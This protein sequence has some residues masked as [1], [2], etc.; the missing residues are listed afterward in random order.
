MPSKLNP[1]DEIP[2]A[3]G[4]KR[5]RVAYEA[6]FDLHVLN[7]ITDS[8]KEKIQHRF[9]KW[10]SFHD[11]SLDRGVSASYRQIKSMTPD[12]NK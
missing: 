7:L 5:W 6:I 9:K 3:N 8:E 1:L 12:S 11:L 2:A 4:E 10:L